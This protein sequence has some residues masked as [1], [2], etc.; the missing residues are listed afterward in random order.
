MNASAPSPDRSAVDNQITA[1]IGRL[2]LIAL[3]L[4]LLS[5]VVG[6]GVGYYSYVTSRDA[7][8]EIIYESNHKV[9]R[10]L[11]MHS[12]ALGESMSETEILAALGKTWNDYSEVYIDRGSFLCV[13]DPEGR[14]SL[15]TRDPNAVGTEAD[16]VMTWAQGH[17]GPATTQELAASRTDWVGTNSTPQDADR[18]GAFAYSASLDALISVF[19]PGDVVNE[20]VRGTALPWAVGVGVITVVLLLSL[21]CLHR[22]GLIAQRR[23]HRSNTHLRFEIEERHRVEKELNRLASFPMLNPNVVIETDLD[24]RVHYLNPRA[25]M[26][27]PD[28]DQRRTEHPFL[29]DLPVAAFRAV[30]APTSM[31]REVEVDG[32]W[33]QQVMYYVKETG[34]IRIYAFDVTERK[35]AEERTKSALRE[36]EVLLQE[37][38]HRVKN[39]MQIISSLL[40]HQAAASGDDRIKAILQESQN[41]VLSMALIHQELYQSADLA[42]V[43]LAPYIRKLAS[44]LFQSYGAEVRDIELDLQMEE[45]HVNIETAIPCGLIV[46]ELLSNALKHAFPDGRSGVV[47]VELAREDGDRYVLWVSDDG[48]GCREVDMRTADSLGLRLVQDLTRQLQGDLEIDCDRGTG[49]Q[50]TFSETK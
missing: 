34:R 5:I 35:Q 26:L 30:D 3:I 48:I 25:E 1:Y 31:S 10:A 23:L 44:G 33:C 15:H 36:K 32:H 22:A 45:V 2:S 24:G 13:I 28:I 50:L 19:V 46:N 42:R 9:A 41:R 47:K 37:V 6:L 4:G 11:A 38:Y 7:L 40:S 29:A 18:I 16:G 20:T 27:Y 43:G 14:L 21:A 39:N 49:F 12:N 17:V 8:L